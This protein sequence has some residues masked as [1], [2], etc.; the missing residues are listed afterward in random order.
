MD[1]GAKMTHRG[2]DSSKDSEKV[3]AE[4]ES[5]EDVSPCERL[6][7][8]TPHRKETHGAEIEGDRSDDAWGEIRSHFKFANPRAPLPDR[9]EELAG[10]SRRETPIHLGRHVNVRP[11]ILVNPPEIRAILR[12]AQRTS[13]RQRTRDVKMRIGDTSLRAYA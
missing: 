5:G 13:S 9:P 1:Y 7:R 10:R 8:G 12:N 4:E 2:R 11:S 6:R 3:H